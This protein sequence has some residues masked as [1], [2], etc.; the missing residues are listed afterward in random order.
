[1]IEKVAW[2]GAPSDDRPAKGI[3]L[4]FS[5]LGA[6]GLKAEASDNDKRLMD[7]GAV[8]ALPYH[9]P[10]AWMNDA[11]VAF[12]DELVDALRARYSLSE[13]SPLIATGGSMGGH[14]ALAYALLSQRRVTACYA[15]CPVCD[16]PFH[17]SERPD[18]PRTMHSAYGSY[19]DILALLES[20][21]PFDQAAG[22][23]DIPYLILHGEQDK[24][25]NKAAHS[26]KL[27]AKLRARGLN[28]DYREVVEMAHCGPIGPE[29]AADIE[30]FLLANLT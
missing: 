6:S 4:Q 7:A 16:L 3:V 2:I 27:V 30:A 28:V 23:P 26:D 11:T 5:G 15:N 10:W 24:S 17:Y 21:S 13:T 22:M 1:M 12:V 19:G 8:V 20:H 29:L 18:L 9:N 25:V 14:G